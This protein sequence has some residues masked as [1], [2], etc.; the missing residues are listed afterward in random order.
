MQL[1][2]P[3]TMRARSDSETPSRLV[4]RLRVKSRLDCAYPQHPHRQRSPHTDQCDSTHRTSPVDKFKIMLILDKGPKNMTFIKN[5]HDLEL[6][7]WTRRRVAIDHAHF[8]HAVDTRLWT[9]P[10]LLMAFTLLMITISPESRSRSG[11]DRPEGQTATSALPDPTHNRSYQESLRNSIRT[12]AARGPH[13]APPLNSSAVAT[14]ALAPTYSSLLLAMR[15]SFPKNIHSV[16]H[17][18]HAVVYLAAAPK[19]A[20]STRETPTEYRR[21]LTVSADVLLSVSENFDGPSPS[22]NSSSMCYAIPN[23]EAGNALM[24]IVDY[25]R[26]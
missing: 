4:A 20:S 3:A 1:I 10:T 24:T 16:V 6:V 18:S 19:W 12:F 9:T 23:Q 17:E 26:S 8:E 22:I 7:D 11:S 2:R 14:P 21:E 5:Q 13:A 25:E 15:L